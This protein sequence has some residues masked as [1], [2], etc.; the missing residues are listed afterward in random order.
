MSNGASVN[1]SVDI[2]VIWLYKTALSSEL[3]YP[4]APDSNRGGGLP[5]VQGTGTLYLYLFPY[6]FVFVDFIP[7]FSMGLWMEYNR[8]VDKLHP[9]RRGVNF[10]P[11][12]DLTSIVSPE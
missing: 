5:R 3:S 11:S 4:G 1:S 8:D 9:V 12:G 6:S 7:T 10:I 2:P